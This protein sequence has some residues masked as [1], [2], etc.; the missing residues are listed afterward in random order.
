ML[1]WVRAFEPSPRAIR[2]HVCPPIEHRPTSSN[3][4]DSVH[5][6]LRGHGIDPYAAFRDY[7]AA[8][9]TFSR[10]FATQHRVL[11]SENSKE[12]HPQ[13]HPQPHPTLSNS[14]PGIHSMPDSSSQLNA[15]I[16]QLGHRLAHTML[17]DADRRSHQ[18]HATNGSVDMASEDEEVHDMWVQSWASSSEDTG[19]DYSI[20]EAEL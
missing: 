13:P 7:V 8:T 15:T 18:T 4:Q 17:E 2:A 11:I 1:R 10:L 5:S 12:P 19:S 6:L 3:T 9:G 14:P 20:S 16:K